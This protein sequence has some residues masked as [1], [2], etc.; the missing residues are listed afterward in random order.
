[1]EIVMTPGLALALLIMALWVIALA[2]AVMV[3]GGSAMLFEVIKVVGR[4]SA[5]AWVFSG[6]GK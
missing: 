2:T 4:V 5:A 1:M 3:K 6:C